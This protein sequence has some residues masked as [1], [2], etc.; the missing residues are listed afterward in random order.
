MA[1][2]DAVCLGPSCLGAIIV[3]LPHPPFVAVYINVLNERTSREQRHEGANPGRLRIT[4]VVEHQSRLSVANVRQSNRKSVQ[5]ACE[6][7]LVAASSW[8]G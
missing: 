8:R 7:D 2:G 3:A 1:E 6:V 5:S 4:V